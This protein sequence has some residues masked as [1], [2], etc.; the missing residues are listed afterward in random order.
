V[1]ELSIALGN[2]MRENQCSPI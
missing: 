2:L 1:A